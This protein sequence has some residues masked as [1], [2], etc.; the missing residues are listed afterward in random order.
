MSLKENDIRPRDLMAGLFEEVEA[1]RA[2]LAARAGEFER[3]VCPACGAAGHPSF[4]KKDFHYDRCPACRTAFM[5]PRP[6]E[7]LLH[8]FYA[9]S[10]TYAYWNRHI[11]PASEAARRERIFAPRAERVLGF[12]SRY[13]I[14]TGS[15]LEIGAGFGT[16]CEEIASRRVFERVVALEMTP[17]L[18]QTCRGRGLE[19][20]EQPVEKLDWAAHSVDV[21]AAFETLEHLHSPRAFLASCKRFLAP[22]G[23]L[24]LTC[25]SI[26]G[27][28]V[29]TLGPASDTV[30]HEHLNYFNPASIR[31]LAESC[32]FRVL[33]VLTPGQLDA[34]IVRNKVAGGA[35]SL[36][37]QP[38]LH[39]ILFERW[40]DLGP[41]FQT[42]L[43]ENQLSTHMWMVATI[44]S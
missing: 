26:D 33:E 9:Q 18:A 30:D 22:G 29:I 13:G 5:N 28:D 12:C 44:T 15:L 10:R 38:W 16:F 7:S 3:A 2:W 34:D 36:D 21:M 39:H 20:V 19:V 43:S 11:F 4:E 31:L 23:L 35:F 42:F 41:K 1:D 17:D 32:G 25:P 24:V 14:K 8:A 6:P 40:E 37:G 27:F